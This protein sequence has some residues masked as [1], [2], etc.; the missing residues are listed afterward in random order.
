[1][2]VFATTTRN[3]SS[4]SLARNYIGNA[5]A[6][7]LWINMAKHKDAIQSIVRAW[8]EGEAIPN[9]RLYS[10]QNPDHKFHIHR[11]QVQRYNEW[12]VLLN[13]GEKILFWL[14]TFVTFGLALV[15]YYKPLL[16]FRHHQRAIAKMRIDGKRLHFNG[17]FKEFRS[18]YFKN[19]LLTTVTLGIYTWWNQP[20]INV[21]NY[22]DAHIDWAE[23][24]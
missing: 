6:P 11:P 7:V 8:N 14:L 12:N 17:E 19:M 3:F 2:Q 10:V 24:K 23:A 5:G 20:E 22:L 16:D 15:F 4:L 18:V 21:A 9:R 1:V 13:T